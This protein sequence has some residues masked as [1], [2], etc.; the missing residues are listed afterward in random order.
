M[1]LSNF[2]RHLRFQRT[3]TVERGCRR[4]ERR[5]GV[6][7]DIGRIKEMDA[8]QFLYNVRSQW[9]EIMILKERADALSASLGAHGIDYSGERVQTS[10]DDQM[11]RKVAA[12]ADYKSELTEKEIGLTRDHMRAQQMIDALEDTRERQVLELYFLSLPPKSMSMTAECVGYS[13]EHTYRLF[14]R[15]LSKLRN[16]VTPQCDKLV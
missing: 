13:R 7:L 2:A 5:V 10:P 11:S 3:R 16:N 4:S 12:L 14:A 1:Q 15:A 8:R 9:K 6:G